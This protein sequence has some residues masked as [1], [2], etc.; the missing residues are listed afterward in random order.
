VVASDLLQL[1]PAANQA[2]YGQGSG[3]ALFLPTRPSGDFVIATQIN[4]HLVGNVNA[5]PT[6]D[7]NVCGLIARGVSDPS[8]WVFVASGRGTTNIYGVTAPAWQ[9]ELR[10]C[11]I[12][13]T[14][15]MYRRMN[16]DTGFVE[17]TPTFN[18]TDLTGAV[19][20]GLAANGYTAAPNVQ[21]DYDWVRLGSVS[22]LADCT[23]ELHP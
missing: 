12:G 16:G 15:R 17:L 4:P 10:L 1:V 3:P 8:D 13:S 18:R 9:G 20:V 11:R 14:F 21:C 5:R 2:W 22:T 23:A 6:A 7:Y 19:D